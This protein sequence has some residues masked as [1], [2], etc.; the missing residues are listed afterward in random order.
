[1]EIVFA[2]PLAV[3]LLLVKLE[4][5]SVAVTFCA[6]G[7]AEGRCAGLASDVIVVIM[8]CFGRDVLRLDCSLDLIVFAASGVSQILVH[9]NRVWVN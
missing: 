7:F 3:D 5:T 8:V 1:M 9:L 2:T 6:L 4:G